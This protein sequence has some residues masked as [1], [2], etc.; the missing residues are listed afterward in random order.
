VHVI[1]HRGFWLSREE[2]NTAHAFQRSFQAG[3]GAEIDVRDL[4]G[5]LVVSHDPPRTGAL[6]FA[7]VLAAYHA[8]GCPGTLAVNVKADGLASGLRA[9]LADTPSW[10]AF[11]MSVP[12]TLQYARD[13]VPFFTRESEYEPHPPLYEA[14]S[15]VWIDCF[16]GDWIDEGVVAAHLDAG[17]AV[18]LVSPEVHGRPQ[19]NTWETWRRWSVRDDPRMSV[20][21]DLPQR[22][23]EFL[24]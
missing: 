15:G 10:F 5:Q 14:A 20:C 22:A 16:E 12:E 18:C 2:R 21:T 17:K 24:A 11:D 8:A 6:A 3:F 19:D 4:D 7:E 23:S 1:S 13:S 9:A